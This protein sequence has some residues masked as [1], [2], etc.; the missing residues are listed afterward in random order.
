MLAN[1][2]GRW[3]LALHGPQPTSDSL[4]RHLRAVPEATNVFSLE[5][6]PCLLLDSQIEGLK[7]RARHLPLALV[8]LVLLPLKAFDVAEALA[9]VSLAGLAVGCLSLTAG[10]RSGGLGP[11]TAPRA[12]HALSAASAASTADP[13][14]QPARSDTAL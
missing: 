5:N 11:R 14:S 12:S 4:S 10:G 8:P 2:G 9:G 6:D 7:H 13:S 1:E 3:P